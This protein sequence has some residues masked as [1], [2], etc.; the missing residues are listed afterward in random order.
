MK[1]TIKILL[2]VLCCMAMPVSGW[3]QKKTRKVVEAAMAKGQYKIHVVRDSYRYS[4]YFN[5]YDECWVTVSNCDL[6]VEDFNAFFNKNPQYQTEEVKTRREFKYRHEHYYV[7]S[8]SFHNN[9]KV[10]SALEFAIRLENRNYDLKLP[11]F[12]DADKANT[13]YQKYVKKNADLAKRYKEKFNVDFGKYLKENPE[14]MKRFCEGSP[15]SNNDLVNQLDVWQL[16]WESNRKYD[17]VF[18]RTSNNGYYFDKQKK[19][20]YQGDLKNGKP[21]GRGK[22]FGWE[23]T[24]TDG[25]KNG[26]FTLYYTNREYHR[27]DLGIGGFNY[28]W[29]KFKKTGKCVNDEW[30]GEVVFEITC[31]NHSAGKDVVKEYYSKGK[32]TNSTL[33]S[34]ALSDDL[35]KKEQLA[36][37]RNSEWRRQREAERQQLS[38]VTEN[39]V[40]QY[41]KSIEEYQSLPNTYKVIFKDGKS[42]DIKY[43]PS[44]G[45]WGA[46]CGWAFFFTPDYC[47]PSPNSKAAA[48]FKLFKDKH[49]L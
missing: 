17:Y 20:A 19:Y 3:C 34:R 28:E 11:N 30:E 6:E 31:P 22:N 18:Y 14:S 48:I 46:E 39:T 42:G 15:Y 45:G 2:I 49:D 12:Q 43:D 10:L 9:H 24:F 32:C 1:R 23:G 29:F 4:D 13:F 27:S 16:L 41:V 40:M 47:F 5:P 36:S 8:F 7:T 38:S 26:Q 25:K 35:R 44:K 37:E 21:N 33:V